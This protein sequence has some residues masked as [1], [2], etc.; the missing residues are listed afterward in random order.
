MAQKGKESSIAIRDL[1]IQHHQN[2]KSVRE[3]A[4]LVK[5]AKSTVQD[6]I[7]KFNIN[8]TIQNKSER[9][10]KQILTERDVNSIVREVK[11]NRRVSA[12]K[13]AK[14]IEN[15]TD[16]S[17]SASTISRALHKKKLQRLYP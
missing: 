17:V 13:L 5:K 8:R 4:I 15:T 11:K 2:R 9:R 16:K 3:I 7:K 10:R 6:I 1:I 12:A 14:M